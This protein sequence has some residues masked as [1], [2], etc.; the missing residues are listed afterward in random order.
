MRVYVC[1]GGA[2]GTVIARVW[3]NSFA[4]IAGYAEVCLAPHYRS[5]TTNT[6]YQEFRDSEER[7]S[8]LRTPHG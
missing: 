8:K 2:Q 4:Q 7:A 1:V 3:D 6:V 5:G